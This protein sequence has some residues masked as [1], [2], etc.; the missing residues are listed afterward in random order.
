M[1]LV[2][3]SILFTKTLSSKG[4]S[5][6]DMFTVQY[7]SLQVLHALE[8]LIP[9]SPSL[10]TIWARISG[11]LYKIATARSAHRQP[12]VALSSK[13]WRWSD[14]IVDTEVGYT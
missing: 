10:H 12:E 14:E 3:A 8:D 9:S 6:L 5:L 7:R 2:G 1:D 13:C 4:I 11:S